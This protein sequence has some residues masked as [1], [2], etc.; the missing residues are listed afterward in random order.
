MLSLGNAFHAEDVAEFLG[1]I[2]RFLGLDESET[3]A[4]I[5]EPKIDGLS[6]SLRYEKGLLVQGATR[7]DGAVGEDI[8]Q[9]VRTIGEIPE[10]LQ[11]K[12]WPEVLE[13]RGEVYMRREDFQTLNKRQEEAGGKVFANPRNAA[14]GSL[15]QLD[16]SITAA[17]PLRFFGYAW[18]EVSEPLGETMME[19]QE[20]LQAWGFTIN[21]P[22]RLCSSLEEILDYYDMVMSARPELPFDI[23][24]V[25]YK[26]NR[27]D[28]QARLG[29]VSRAPRWAIAHKFPAEK[30]V[31]LLHKI[32]I[33]VGRTGS[34]TPVAHLEPITV[35]GV[36]VSR[37]TLHNEDEIERK[38]IREGD[39]VVI[40][41]A[42]DVIP[43]VVSVVLD[44]RTKDSAPYDFPKV[45]PECGS[46]AVREEGEAVRRCSGGLI[47]PAQAVERLRHFVSRHAL[48][49]EGL[50]E[51][52]VKF[53]FDAGLVH[54][55]G[56][57]F[58]L[59]ENDAQSD[60][61]L[62]EQPGW[63][64]QSAENLFQA[65]EDRRSVPLDRLIYGLGIR[66]TGRENARLLAKHYGSM[67]ALRA[68][69]SDAA[70][71]A[72]EAYQQLV[73][74]DGIGPVVVQALIE[75]FT[76]DQNRAVLDDLERELTIEEFV[77]PDLGDS[78][79]AGKTVVF[80]GK[81]E[82]FTRDEAKAKAEALGAKVSGSVSAK[83]DFLVAGPG[84][85]SKAKKAADLGVT[86]LSEDE[87][88][89][90]IGQA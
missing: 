17:R 59:R 88:L 49:I 61:P 66:H 45:C 55:P 42:G 80:T 27:L 23:D 32:A 74:V 77:A 71:P 1:R 43:Q 12:G 41:R 51:K 76:E 70:E 50:G 69:V 72:S 53:F 68:A 81:L 44:K 75:F 83:T 47:C 48:D 29:F 62:R 79:V 87:W 26:V 40:Q 35:G 13:V 5:A 60:T 39:H 86:T 65:I 22:V 19:A 33:Q 28:L 38:D 24:G 37:A 8:T 14:A 9:N 67:T 7:G 78:P 15:R 16:V 54:R 11:G 90:L 4:V 18:G 34:L 31:T 21:D 58:R 36:V 73:A 63:G 6:C 89:A 52:Q 85:G 30:A 64:K 56:D 57:I 10:R 84:A 46:H 25:V 3:P 82:R 2:T 20:N